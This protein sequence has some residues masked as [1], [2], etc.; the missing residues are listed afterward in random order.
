MKLIC[1]KQILINSIIPLTGVVS[2]KSTI[3]ALEGI[4]F[5]TEGRE[6]CVLCGYDL[7]KGI[8]TK[9]ECAVAEE[10]NYVINAA[11]LSQIV[12]AMP[13]GPITVEV[14]SKTLRTRIYGGKA[15]FEMQALGGGDYPDLPDLN[16]DRGFL[17]KR[18]DLKNIFDKTS[19]AVA[20]NDSRPALNG[21]FMKLSGSVITAV[22]C[23]GN[24]LAV[25]EQKCELE[26]TES[27][28]L[29]DMTFLIPGKTVS[30]LVKLLGDGEKTLK[31]RLGRKHVIFTVDEF[32]LFTRQIDAEYVDYNRFIPASSKIEVILESDKLRSAL[33]RAILITENK[34]QGQTKSPV[35][36]KFTGSVL[37]VSSCSITEQVNDDINIEKEGEDIEIGFNCRFL[38]DA[39]RV[40]D[41]E[42]IKLALNSPLM[43]MTIEP[44][45]TMKPDEAENYENKRFLLLVLPVR[46]NKI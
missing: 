8:R 39:M 4:Q 1:D 27:G 33:E 19:F 6:S 32:V 41:T 7:E 35:I 25:F 44:D 37:N 15:V 14:D 13:D 23:D 31:I 16:G 46:L 5:R 18:Q 40:C 2:N 24:R 3:A 21:L 28:E 22:G 45:F 42:Y 10:G 36:L 17:I 11:K 9:I 26:N 29:P 12:R 43:S 38:L 20:I 34:Q 30:E